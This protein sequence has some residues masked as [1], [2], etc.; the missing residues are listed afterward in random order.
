MARPSDPP[1]AAIVAIDPAG[2]R[3]LAGSAAT[4][5]REARTS[6]RVSLL[7]RLIAHRVPES[8]A[9]A[10]ADD[11]SRLSHGD[12]V[13]A[14]AGALQSR[15][16]ARPIDY[17]RANA[18]LLKGVHGAGKTTVAA[19]I[20][21][22]A[23]LTG[24]KVQLLTENADDLRLAE[25]SS[26][27]RVKIA[28]PK[29][30]QAIA[31]AVAEAVK[32]KSLVVIDTSGFNPRRA[33]ARAAF[34]ALAQIEKVLTIG[35]VSALYDAA[36]MTDFIGGLNANRTVVTGLDLTRRAGA[37]AVAATTHVP[38]AHVARS[39]FVGDGLEPLTPM[40]LAQILLGIKASFR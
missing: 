35:V 36:E 8:L 16:R 32:K 14:L 33:K 6:R 23:Y 1:S 22:Q 38:I 27:L 15:M 39:P 11:A 3:S 7:A 20:A 25:L 10:L 9:H 5:E 13:K 30:A 18:V 31:R 2:R 37:L 4:R 24:R 19:K 26:R 12:E 29:N 40:A 34:D 17:V 21:A 28:T